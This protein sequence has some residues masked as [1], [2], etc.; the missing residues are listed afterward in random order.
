MRIVGLGVIGL[1]IASTVLWS[2]GRIV[3]TSSPTDTSEL[4][5][6]LSSVV[7][8]LLMS[9]G[10]A[11]LLRRRRVAG[12]RSLSAALTVD[13]LVTM[14]FEFASTQFG[15]LVGFTIQLLLLIGVRTAM[16]AEQEV[17]PELPRTA[18]TRTEPSPAAAV[19]R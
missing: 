9:L 15:A 19:S 11:L 5:A 1:E 8:A 14:I 17:A 18:A 3:D 13:L 16:A 12:L 2:I 6:L 10:I 7:S 4:G